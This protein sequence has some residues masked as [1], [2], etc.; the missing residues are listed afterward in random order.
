ML[1]TY[2][3]GDASDYANSQGWQF[4]RSGD[5]IILHECPFCGKK[6]KLYWNDISGAFDCKAGVCQQRGNYFTLR[7]DIG[8]PVEALTAPKLVPA[9]KAFRRVPLAEFAK[10]ESQLAASDTAKAYLAGRGIT[11]EQAKKW[12]L[13]LKQ[14]E[15]IDWLMIPYI[16]K[17]GDIADVKYRSLPPA[18]KRFRRRGGGESILFGEHLLPDK[19]SQADTIYLCE[20]ELDCITLDQHG[21]SPAISTTTGAASFSPRWYDMIISSGAKRLILIYDSDVDGQA[22]AEK[23]IKKFNDAERQVINVVLE[24]CKDS[25]EFFLTHTAK[26]LEKLIADAR[27]VEI[28]HVLSMG[29]VLDRLEEQ[30]FLSGS[31][32]NGIPSQFQNINEL[33]D[34]GYW[35]GFLVTVVGASGTGKTSFVLQELVNISSTVGPAYMC[36]LEMPEEMMLRKTINHLY[37]VP[38]KDIKGHHIQQ[39]RDDLMRRQLYFG[40]GVRN[41]DVLEDVFR[42][43]A[44]RHDLKAICFDNI[45]YLI[46]DSQNVTAQMG[47]VTR[48]LKDLAVDLNIPIFQIAQPKKFKRDERVISED[49]IKDAASVEQDSDVLIML[50]RPTV[51]TDITDFGKTVGQKTSMSPLTLIRVGK[52]RYSPGG[53]TLLYFHGEIGTF[54]ELSDAEKASITQN[55]FNGRNE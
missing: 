38:I 16:T 2:K 54:R 26:D 47:V 15:G 5:E 27:P 51:K 6:D 30:I 44:K 43:A 10:F 37:H 29:T 13:G 34:G 4:K 20:G 40:S 33:I 31:G 32:L 25:N 50:W 11:L 52:A 22:G 7:R 41:I 48:R 28:E 21:F 1:P 14:D 49:D 19:K 23:L 18:P 39:Y 42:K 55:G 45:N 12:H 36:C 8:D 53:E 17:Q 3:P 24:D 9:K 46:R 35:N